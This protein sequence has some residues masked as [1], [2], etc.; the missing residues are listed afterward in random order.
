MKK[1]LRPCAHIGCPNLTRE[2]YCEEHKTQGHKRYDN[3]R[4]TAAQRGYDR[5]WR[6]ARIAFLR[7]NPLCVQCKQEGRLTPA[8]VVDHVIPHKGNREL[9]W[10]EDN[11]QALCASCHSAKTAREDGGFN[12]QIK[13]R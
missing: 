6:K 5:R 7:R 12:N 11:W 1:P 13:E 8:T 4:G 3:K 2:R 9:F 10:A